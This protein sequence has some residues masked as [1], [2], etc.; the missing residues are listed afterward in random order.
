MQ[1]QVPNVW[2]YKILGTVSIALW[3][4]FKSCLS[5]LPPSRFIS[6]LS[7]Q[8]LGPFSGLLWIFCGTVPV[9]ITPVAGP[10]LGPLA[11][12][13]LPFAGCLQSISKELNKAK[14]LL[15]VKITKQAQCRKF[16]VILSYSIFVSYFLGIFLSF[17]TVRTPPGCSDFEPQLN[18]R[19]P[20]VFW[21]T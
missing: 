20:A 7:V 2:I 4:V 21:C 1:I 16:C 13:C 18:S 11:S 15:Y 17:Q 5:S 14:Y 19:I 6:S 8:F 9:Q 3:I 10:C 12:L